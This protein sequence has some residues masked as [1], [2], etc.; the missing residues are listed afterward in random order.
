MPSMKRCVDY[1]TNRGRKQISAEIPIEIV[2]QLQRIAEE[3]DVSRQSL[4]SRA[5]REF[6]QRYYAPDDSPEIRRFPAS[7]AAL[8]AR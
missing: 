4:V 2:E 1:V 5:V 7:P 3:Q 8:G 6:V